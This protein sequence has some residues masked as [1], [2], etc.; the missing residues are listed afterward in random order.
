MDKIVIHG[1][2]PLR[3]TIPIS[4]AKNS[5]LP[6]MAA[7]LLTSETL[8]LEN[9]PA[10]GDI[11]TLCD[12]LEG[13]GVEIQRGGISTEGVLT[14]NAAN[15]A[16]TTAPYE[17]VRK[18][19]ASVLVLGPLLARF[20]TAT[21]SLPGGC[22]IGTRPVDLHIRALEQ[23]GAE[24][25]LKDGYI[26]AVAP[27]GLK[28]TAIRF[29]GV[30]VGGTENLLMAAT[31]A[32]GETVIENAAR[33]PEVGALADCLV[34]MGADISGIGTERVVVRGVA[35]LAG[36]RVTNIPDRIEAGSYAVAAAATDG[37]LVLAGAEPAHMGAVIE[38]LRT[39]GVRVEEVSGGLRVRRNGGVLSGIYIMT[40]PYPGFP[41]DMQAQMMV[42]M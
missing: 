7:S 3:G 28:G 13:L 1:G 17:L 41:T 5:A 31:L 38:A 27:T 26:H 34:A 23:M 11:G 8:T 40:Q 18:M 37:D 21:V 32:K 42:L 9:I 35:T 6:L 10:L 4:G 39:A 20:G 36:A 19:R 29:P 33:E 12:L 25:D 2:K 15:V 22:A 16:D 24:I 14:L 30:T